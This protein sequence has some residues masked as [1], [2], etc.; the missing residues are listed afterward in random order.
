MLNFGLYRYQKVDIPNFFVTI[1]C[2][3]GK[4]HLT[5]FPMKYIQAAEET[6]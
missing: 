4:L 6:H 2:I 1:L 3:N 5:F